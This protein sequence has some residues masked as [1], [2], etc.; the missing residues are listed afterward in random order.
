M[1]DLFMFYIGGPVNGANIEIHDVQFAAVESAEEAFPLLAERWFGEQY[2]LH[3]DCYSRVTWVDGYD[4][5]LSPEPPSSD[6]K[7]WFI[8]MGGYHEGV[9]QE[10][11]AIRLFVAETKVEAQQRAKQE[12]FTDVLLQHRD[13]Q[14]DIDECILLAEIQGLHV[15]LRP[16]PEGSDADQPEFL[17]YQPIGENVL[18]GKEGFSRIRAGKDPVP[19]Y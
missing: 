10:L 11:H 13:N 2:N 19:D 14:L 1:S 7:L 15:H 12:V 6:K 9:F 8:N 4:V 18:I 17:G 5:I 3:I 16:N